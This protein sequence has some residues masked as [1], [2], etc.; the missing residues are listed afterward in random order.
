ML[1]EIVTE[2]AEDASCDWRKI[3]IHKILIVSDSACGRT[4]ML[5]G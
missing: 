5:N 2:T 1:R 4:G 3:L